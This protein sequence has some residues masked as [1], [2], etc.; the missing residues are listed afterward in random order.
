[1]WLCGLCFQAE[2][3]SKKE[4]GEGLTSCKGMICANVDPGSRNH[5]WNGAWPGLGLF[6]GDE[7]Q[8]LSTWSALLAPSNLIKR[9]DLGVDQTFLKVPAFSAAIRACCEKVKQWQ[10][11]HVWSTQVW[12]S[13]AC[14][15]A[16]GRSS[17]LSRWFKYQFSVTLTWLKSWGSCF[18][19]TRSGALGRNQGAK[20]I[21]WCRYS[22]C[23]FFRWIVWGYD[24]STFFFSCLWRAGAWNDSRWGSLSICDVWVCKG[25]QTV[26]DSARVGW[27][28]RSPK[29]WIHI[30]QFSDGQRFLWFI[31]MYFDSAKGSCLAVFHWRFKGD[32]K[33][34]PK[35]QVWQAAGAATFTGPRYWN[36]RQESGLHGSTECLQALRFHRL[37]VPIQTSS[38]EVRSR[39]FPEIW[40]RIC[41]Y[42]TWYNV[43]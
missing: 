17:P 21:S 37:A 39:L 13:R 34:G 32:A 4:M 7:R 5:R 27:F 16:L 12:Y 20:Q 19:A 24:I 30:R 22:P 15:L 31:W 42:D 11:W 29:S 25:A 40:P 6:T 41:K 14:W 38:A 1:M 10:H 35:W 2:V 26:F 43:W 8:R 18:Q 28:Q 3:G 9:F 23:S 36:S 33:L